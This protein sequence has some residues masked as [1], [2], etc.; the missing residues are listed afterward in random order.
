M[1]NE[2]VWRNFNKIACEKTSDFAEEKAR[3]PEFIYADI[4]RIGAVVV[5][6]SFFGVFVEAIVEVVELASRSKLFNL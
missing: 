1:R 3:P 2:Q 5:I 6:G 4:Y